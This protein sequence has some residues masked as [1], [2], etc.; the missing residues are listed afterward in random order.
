MTEP[1]QSVSTKQVRDVVALGKK[2]PRLHFQI[3][4]ATAVRISLPYER[5]PIE[6]DGSAWETS[7]FRTLLAAL[8][9]SK[10]TPDC[11]VCRS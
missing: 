7:R 6:I 2:T 9:A 8:L 3:R 5:W 4:S 11:A 10:S 1:N